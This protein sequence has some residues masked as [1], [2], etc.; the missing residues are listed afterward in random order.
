VINDKEIG[1]KFLFTISI[2]E[3][4][5]ISAVANSTPAKGLKALPIDAERFIGKS[6]E[7]LAI[8]NLAAALG[9]NGPNAK[10]AAFPLP[11][12]M[13]AK[14]IIMV[15]IIPSPIAPKPKP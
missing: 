8:P 10:K 14:N 3:T 1:I 6:I 7:V 13:A 15:I 9:I 11:I 5:A 4:P 2:D 12:S